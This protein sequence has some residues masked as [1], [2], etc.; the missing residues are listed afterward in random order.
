M[1]N[2]LINLLPL[3]R[4]KALRRDYFLRLGVVGAV[5]LCVLT[6]ISA[7]LLLPT[8]VYLAGN[9][10]A[11]EAQLVNIKSN[12]SSADETALSTRLVALT[13]DTTIL[14]ALVN[15]PSATAIIRAALAV[16]RFGATLSSFTYTPSANGV[17][18]T[19]AISGVAI[20]RDALRNYQL[21]LQSSLFARSA[22][23]PVSAYAQN[24]HIAF[25]ITVTLAP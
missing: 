4:Q 12:L 13:N 14:T 11:K 17:P 20:T 9:V 22:T 16:P 21:A 2:E 8:Y 6:V 3:K 10:R 24:T 19:L 7:V 15:T 18:G 5:L 1:H 23:L 25:I